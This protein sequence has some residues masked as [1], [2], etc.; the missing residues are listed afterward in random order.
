[1]AGCR[2]GVPCHPAAT[3]LKRKERVLTVRSTEE[4]L[5]NVIW[6]I[7]A[8]GDEALAEVQDLP[9][10]EMAKDITIVSVSSQLSAAGSRTPGRLNTADE[11]GG[12]F[13]TRIAG[14]RSQQVVW[15]TLA[16]ALLILAVGAYAPLSAAPASTPLPRVGPALH[17]QRG[18]LI[19][20]SERYVIEEDDV[21]VFRRRPVEI[22]TDTG[23][24]VGSYAPVGDTP[25]R[26]DV[27]PGNDIVV[28]PRQGALQKVR[29]SVKDGEETIVPES[30]PE[31]S[32]PHAPVSPR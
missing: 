14:F 29:A 23:Q 18:I 4:I 16:S 5:G 15:L 30:L 7:D 17:P 21:L 24:L 13:L 27:P 25:L 11:K 8:L 3:T 19:V 32:A 31:P 2:V 22:Y 12:P 10:L 20:Y 1:L 28:S 6:L 26:L 9:F